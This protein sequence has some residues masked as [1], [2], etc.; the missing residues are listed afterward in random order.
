MAPTA[1]LALEA[2][3]FEVI[4]EE[5]SWWRS[6][7]ASHRLWCRKTESP[8][9]SAMREDVDYVEPWKDLLELREQAARISS[10]GGR[11]RRIYR[12]RHGHAYSMAG[13]NPLAP[14]LILVELAQYALPSLPEGSE[15][16]LP[17]HVVRAVDSRTDRAVDWSRIEAT[18]ARFV[19][20]VDRSASISAIA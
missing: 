13:E 15:G 12:D 14:L 2:L 17:L 6:L 10:A 4:K 9:A 16:R 20:A 1:S 8:S 11:P 7:P 19:D 3:G 18:F 5:M